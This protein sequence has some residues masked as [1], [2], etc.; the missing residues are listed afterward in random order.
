MTSP[1]S[2]SVRIVAELRERLKTE[3]GLDD[4][5]EALETTIEGET[6]LPEQIARL[7][8]AAL[9]SEAYAEGMKALIREN[10]ERKARLETRA[11]KLR[12]VI[13][14]AM[15]DSGMTK[16]PLPDMSLSLSQGKPP[17]IVDEGAVIPDELCRIK[18]EPDK[19]A[20]RSALDRGD[21]LAFARIGNA[22]QVLTIRNR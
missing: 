12:G 3:F 5:D 19:T 20:I 22:G 6:D 4:G 17:L 2:N 16:L 18:R 7:A 8:R 15:S 1:L 10:A 21:N 11:A 9:R 14:W 13:A